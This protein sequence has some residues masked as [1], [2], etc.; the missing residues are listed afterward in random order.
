M[1]TIILCG[2]PGCGKT[3]IGIELA[4]KTSGKMINIDSLIEQKYNDM[5]GKNLNCRQIY[6]HKGESFFRELEKIVIGSLKTISQQNHIIAIGGG[7]MEAKKNLEVLEAL[8]TIVYLKVDPKKAFERI[9]LNGLPAYLDP[10]YPFDSFMKM[11]AKRIPIF[12]DT[13]QLVIETESLHFS[14]IAEIIFEKISE[15]F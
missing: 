8:G 13:S 1:K 7:A 11:T 4:K 9:T 3:T 15:N 14:Q 5:F 2:L 10:A 12:I 6:I